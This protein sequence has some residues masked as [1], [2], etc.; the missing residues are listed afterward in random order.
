MATSFVV[1]KATH[2]GRRHTLNYENCQ[3]S[4]A[5][6]D[7]DINGQRT[8]IGIVCDGCSSGKQS[9]VGANFASSFLIR[10]AWKVLSIEK[11]VKDIPLIL[12]NE[13]IKVLRDYVSAFAPINP[14]D[15]VD[16][17]SNTLL[18]TVLGFILTPR[19][20]V[21]FSAGDGVVVVN[22]RI[23]IID[24]NNAPMYPAYD[25]LDANHLPSAIRLPGT[26]T[27]VPIRTSTINR[28]AIG[29]DAWKDEQG[30]LKE[31][32]EIPQPEGLQ[33]RLNV[34]SDEQHRFYDDVSIITVES[35]NEGDDDHESP[36]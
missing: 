27:S 25:L 8:V 13:L 30:L 32:W 2:I 26:F 35:V 5:G 19:Q 9:E 17:I 22:D 7:G 31:I 10:E 18:F 16:L 4:V 6:F 12:Y 36:A 33:R 23:K 21:V 20:T 28:L 34:W 11:P 3:D 14:A 15:K 1:H 24:Q 29:T